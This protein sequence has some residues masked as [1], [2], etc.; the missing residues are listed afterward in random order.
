MI[1]ADRRRAARRL[2]TALFGAALLASVTA[3]VRAEEVAGKARPN[4]LFVVLDDLGIDQLPTFGFGGVN[5]PKTPNL[6]KIAAEGVK[7]TNM[8]SM[9]ECSPARA[10]FFAGRYPLRTGVISAIVNNH[11]PQDYVSSFEATIPRVLETA[12][13][14]SALVGKYH[15]G[16]SLDPAGECAPS[17][18]GWDAFR[19]NLNPGPPSIDITAGG[20]DPAGGEVC[21]YVQG[22]DSGACYRL[23]GNKTTCSFIEPANATKGTTPSRTCL[24]A[25]GLFRA[26]QSCGVSVPTKADFETNNAYYVWE[27]FASRGA[28]PPLSLGQ[29]R[30]GK[31][32]R[33]YM[34][35]EQV[36]DGASW[37]NAQ[38]G[39]RM[40]TLAFNAMHTPFQKAPTTVVADPLD[41]TSTCSSTA[42]ERFL[43]NSIIEGADVEIGRMLEK[44]GLAKLD[45]SG[46]RIV[47]L[48]L[49]NTTLIVV[50]DNGSF[51]ST[52]RV[53]DGF[54]AARS[55]ATPY[56]TGVWTPMI[57][58]GAKVQSPGR[59][60]DE[61]VNAVDLFAL[62][63]ELA[64]IDVGSVVP[65]YRTLDSK[66][67]LP[68]L[69][70]T[71]N[72]S[73]RTTS[74]TEVGA[75]TFTPNPEERSWPCTIA[76]LCNDT[77]LF[78]ESLCN[79][80]GGVWSGP[81]A[82]QQYSSCCAVVESGAAQT[83]IPV[84]QVAVRNKRYKLV[85]LESTDCSK[86]LKKGQK[87]AFPWAEYQTTTTRELYD[88]KPTKQNPL[89]MDT[90]DANLIPGCPT[91]PESCVPADLAGQYDALSAE[92]AAIRKSAKPEQTCLAK[93]DGNRDLRVNK[94]DVKNFKV[95]KGVGASQ[96]DINVDSFTDAKDLA[97]IEAN[98]G[99][100][101]LDACTRADLNRDG[102]IDGADLAILVGQRGACENQLCGGDLDGNGVVDAKDDTWMLAAGKSCKAKS[103]ALVE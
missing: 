46:R 23:T 55:K 21:G 41:R 6:D 44:I 40:L 36:F 2:G 54:D 97:I 84:H 91:D 14:K 58:A 66:P 34:T 71:T 20:A 9:P 76:G 11:L 52:V 28:E 16:D 22:N 67:L 53:S 102:V 59:S 61:L 101:C 1:S 93:G 92:L 85:E 96:Y 89:G 65:P 29:C 15:L 7:F 60:V 45:R 12:G 99:L 26:N 78:S 77:L 49:G 43:L 64:G 32:N 39:P 86:P 94:L 38:S 81:G 51:G 5:P 80:N 50:N 18:R 90:A 88:L 56:Q 10:A 79:D 63:G 8:W 98:L 4:I 62:F 3:P 31:Q 100:D 74:Y 27:R 72:K 68:Y 47:K 24:Q 69:A 25:G 48:N 95:F 82:D 73:I 19:G 35:T 103:A 13:Y 33:N 42:P 83:I 87:G 17:T 37:W 30:P 70:Q 57:I 75:G